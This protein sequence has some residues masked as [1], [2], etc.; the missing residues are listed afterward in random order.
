MNTDRLQRIE[1]WVIAIFRY[2]IA[3]LLFA[4]M[5][6]TCID[7]LGRYFFNHPV[8]GGLEL[9]EII[10]AGVI[11]SAL[12]LVTYRGEHV[13][14]DLFSLPGRRLRMIQHVFANLVGAASVAM[15]SYQLWQRGNRLDRAG[16]TTIQIEIPVDLVAYTISVLLAVTALAFLVR[17]AIPDDYVN[18]AN[19]ALRD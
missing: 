11:F 14:V 5:V 10:L 9:T 12:P 16:E 3:A 4:L 1:T 7:V 2:V 17:A 18:S 8:Y 6:L 15:L 19:G 13:V